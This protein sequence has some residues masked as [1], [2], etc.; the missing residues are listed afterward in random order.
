MKCLP[1][2]DAQQ[3]ACFLAFMK[4][5]EVSEMLLHLKMKKAAVTRLA[6]VWIYLGIN[7]AFFCG[8]II[9][10][11]VL[12]FCVIGCFFFVIFK[13]SESKTLPRLS[14][15]LTK[16]IVQIQQAPAL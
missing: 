14:I 4:L 7:T 3:A 12:H 8:I 5:C 13:N 2:E 15:K 9:G 16:H 10:G 1:K 6:G 11:S